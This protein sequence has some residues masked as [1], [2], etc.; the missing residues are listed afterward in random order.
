MWI[1]GA[2]SGI[3]EGLAKKLAHANCK[4]I[5][6]ARREEELERVKLQCTELGAENVVILPLDVTAIAE[7]EACVNKAFEYFGA[8]D[9]LICNA[10]RSQ[11]ALW[12]NVDIQVD[13]DVFEV[14]V[15]GLLNLATLVVR[16]FLQTGS[17]GHIAITSSTVGKFSFPGSRSYTASKHALHGYFESLRIEHYCHNIKVTMLCPG[18]VA[19]DFLKVAFTDEHGKSLGENVSIQD[20]RM[21]IDR[22]AHLSAVAIAN[23]LDEVWIAQQPVLIGYYLSQYMPSISRKIYAVLGCRML[24][25]FRDSRDLIKKE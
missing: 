16:R 15:F 8:I 10:G 23:S 7:H 4:L 25:K 22:C 20:K 1:I 9:I 6:T 12:E 2:S 11:R 24:M 19:T 18:P 5:L 3:G 17:G 21:S 13:K 14:N